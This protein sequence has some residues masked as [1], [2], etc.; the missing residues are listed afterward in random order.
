MGWVQ[1]KDEGK[2]A[3]LDRVVREGVSG[4]EMFEQQPEGNE[5]P[6][7]VASG[8]GV[9]IQRDL[10][11]M[12]ISLHQGQCGCPKMSKEESYRGSKQKVGESQMPWEL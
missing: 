1:E 9:F 7:F 6:T 4:K 11:G 5:G 10:L 2:G 3:V 12:V 8:G